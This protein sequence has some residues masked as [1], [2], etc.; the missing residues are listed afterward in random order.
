MIYLVLIIFKVDFREANLDVRKAYKIYYQ[1]KTFALEKSL[2]DIDGFIEAE[3][4]VESIPPQTK[5]PITDD[6]NTEKT[7]GTHL[8]KQ[9]EGKGPNGKLEKVQVNSSFTEKLFKGI[10][11]F[12]RFSRRSLSS[13]KR[14]SQ[15]EIVKPDSIEQ[16]NPIETNL[17]NLHSLDSMIFQ[18]PHLKVVAPT[19]TLS[20]VPLHLLNTSNYKSV[21]NIDKNW[22]DRVG[23]SQ[24]FTDNICES[25]EDVIESSDDEEKT[26][27]LK[28]SRSEITHINHDDHNANFVG[29]TTTTLK[30]LDFCNIFANDKCPSET[31]ISDSS[32]NIACPG[33]NETTTDAEKNSS[34]LNSYQTC[35]KI[36]SFSFNSLN[37]EEQQAEHKSK[38]TPKDIYRFQYEEL[39][40]SNITVPTAKNVEQ[41][42]RKLPDKTESVSSQQENAREKRLLKKL[43]SNTINEN[44]VKID[45]KKKVFVRGRKKQTF[46]NFKKQMWRNKKKALYNL[47]MNTNGSSESV[48]TCFNC[49][50]TGHFARKC[51]SAK[52]DKLLPVVNSEDE[53]PHPT[54][55]EA[56][57]IAKSNSVSNQ[58]P[59]NDE[60]SDDHTFSMETTNIEEEMSNIIIPQPSSN[61]TF[62]KPYY[63]D[64]TMT[65]KYFYLVDRC[66]F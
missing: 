19:T 55:D 59:N 32:N 18:D 14:K 44:F 35:S 39:I 13:N 8:N 43:Q 53:D 49:G 48:L 54:L 38:T 63:E 57:K 26:Q 45:I 58:N 47:D 5:Q 6:V 41:K 9:Q 37:S 3:D 20:S 30:K 42:V 40:T 65:G 34:S 2:T 22:V 17:S 46:S 60:T 28:K 1:L 50:G 29:D 25:D 56:A 66:L 10:K 15:T 61:K 24:S 64:S 12:K 21:R 7:W 23:Q 4:E 51:K 31:F 27:I 33:T 36:N 11:P 62:V 52:E 16:P